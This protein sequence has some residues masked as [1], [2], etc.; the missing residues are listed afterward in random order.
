MQLGFLLP[1]FCMQLSYLSSAYCT[2]WPPWL[3]QQYDAVCMKFF[4][5][6]KAYVIYLV[7]KRMCDVYE[8]MFGYTNL[9]EAI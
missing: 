1:M 2:A 9:F 4:L 8:V 7:S 3:Y 6:P 5:C